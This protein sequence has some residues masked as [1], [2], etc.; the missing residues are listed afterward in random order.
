[1]RAL[2]ALIAPLAAAVLLL[3][4]ASPASAAGKNCDVSGKERSFGPTY[5]TKLKV[6]GVSCGTGKQVVKAYFKCRKAN[7]GKAGTCGRRVLG[8]RCGEHRFNKIATQYDAN[9]TC[10]NG[11][12][13]VWHTYTQYT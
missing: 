11:S 7:G 9:V 2:L 13:R 6:Q 4:G 8:Y 10:K 5:V 12:R 3:G 1:M